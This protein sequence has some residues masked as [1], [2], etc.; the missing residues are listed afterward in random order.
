VSD[1]VPAGPV[2]AYVRARRRAH[3]PPGQRSDRLT[4]AYGV[5]LYLVISLVIAF[6]LLRQSPARG[7]TAAWL[8]DGGIARA[9]AAALLL[10]LLATLRYATWQGPVVFRAPDVQWLLGAPLARAVLVRSRLVRGLLAGAASGA[11]LGLGAFVPLQAELGIAAGPLVAAATL[12]LAAFGLLAA[13]LSWLVER[14]S[15]ATRAVLRASPL[16]LAF[17]AALALAPGGVAGA[18]AVLWSGPWGWAVG[19][20]A[21]A[22]GA[23][24]PGWP[25]QAALLAAAAAAALLAAWSRAG[26]V[27]VE[28]LARRAAARSG[29]AANLYNLDARGAALVRRQSARSLL[30]V[31]RLRLPRPRWRWLAVPWRDALAIMR[32]PARLGWALAL[33]TAAVLA[34][35]AEPDRAAVVAA[36]ILGAYVG[37]AQLTEPLRVEADQPDASRQLPW[38]WGE[39]VLL[40]CLVPALAL[41]AMG[42]AATGLAWAL[43]LLHG[44]AVWLALAGWPPT[45]AVLVAATA[46][47]GQRGRLSPATLT[48]AYSL[49]ELGGPAYLL[50][51]VAAGPLLAELALGI[52]A[53]VLRGAAGHP[54]VLPNAVTTTAVLLLG[55]L[56]GELAYLRARRGSA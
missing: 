19:P 39:L 53:A 2:L 34:A 32:V 44:A 51:W 37:A 6:R 23:S 33:T 45:A 38:L 9:G 17:A 56:A 25:A 7:A 27:T 30:G 28:D 43:G 3:R 1:P 16:A 10:G 48:T 36:A 14:S 35:A 46:I 18:R 26:A 31:R 29:L 50:G 42:A 24:V 11:L 20:L 8:V 15:T 12:G 55:V 4:N 47:A 21:A 22:A 52:P 54:A 41:A 40:H 13:A 49:G 5:A